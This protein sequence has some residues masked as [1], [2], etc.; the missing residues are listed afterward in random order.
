MGSDSTVVVA[1]AIMKASGGMWDN[2]EP[3]PVPLRMAQ[4]AID[5]YVAYCKDN[6]TEGVMDNDGNVR[7]EQ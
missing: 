6:Y 7:T 3:G 2:P 4:A 1:R 5:A